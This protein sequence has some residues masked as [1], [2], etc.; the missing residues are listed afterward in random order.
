MTMRLRFSSTSLATVAI[1][2]ALAVTASASVPAAGHRAAARHRVAIRHVGRGPQLVIRRDEPVGRDRVVIPPI[3][4]PITGPNGGVYVPTA[5]KQIPLFHEPGTVVDDPASELAGGGAHLSPVGPARVTSVSANVRQNNTAGDPAGS[6]QSENAFTA[7]GGN[8][9]AGWNDGTNFGISPGNTGYAYSTNGG[10]TWTDGGV[11]PVPSSTALH[12]GDPCL[13]N[14]FA[15]HY[16]MSDLYSPDN[17]VTSAVAVTPGSF[18]GGVMV[19]NM[20]VIVASSTSDFLDKEWIAADRISGNVYCTYTRFLAAGGN[21]IEFSRST[22]LGATWSPPMVLTSPAIESVQ[23]SRVVVGPT[24]EIQVIYFV[25]DKGTGNNYMRTQRST[26]QGTSWGPEITL[27]TGPS[28][29][30]S[31]YGSGPAGFNRAGGVGF[32]SMAIDRSGGAQNGRVYATW[33]ETV[34]FYF[35]LLGSLGAVNEI[36][37]N[38]TPGTANPILIGQSIH[39]TMSSTADQ[40]WF[41]FNGVAGQTVIIYLTSGG[42]DGFLRLFACG[43]GAVANRTQLSYIGFGTGLCVYTIPSNG[44][45]FFRVLANSATVGPYTVFTGFDSPDPGDEVG[46]DT[47]D[48][49]IQS[50]PDG[51]SWDNRR[52]VNDDAPL[53]DNAFPEVAVDGAGM[54]YVDWYDH[55][56]D[57]CGIGTDV[58][59]ARS[60]NGSVTFL[61]SVKVNDGP[62][63]NWSN[64]ASNLAPNMGDYISLVADG[65]NVYASFADGRGGSP[66]CWMATI[67]DCATATM[68]SIAPYVAMPDHVDLTWMA[69]DGAGLVAT[70]ERREVGGA[71]ASLGVISPDGDG[72]LSYRDATVRAGTTYEYRLG[73]P[74]PSGTGYF[75]GVTVQVPLDLAFS[76]RALGNPLTGSM[77]FAFKLPGSGTGRIELLDVAGRAVDAKVVSGAGTVRLGGAARGGIYFVRLTAANGR[78]VTDKVVFVE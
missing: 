69:T 50:S 36:E 54:V 71:W 38:N 22:N 56:G 31:N 51:V 39:G 25:F 11:L 46:R 24:G 61:P 47:R 5:L 72:R 16:Y 4:A 21:Q 60:T 27:P 68:I 34:N 14:D 12:E 40:D 55:R 52:V 6:T 10:L 64:V 15:N 78:S 28:G 26:T 66:D 13:T 23:G 3:P 42:G 48:A 41:S 33:E 67:N 53:Y 76:V 8:A 75:G 70:V 18:S 43:G 1:L 17:N 74:T 73:V 37:S 2:A 7:D 32:P 49:I 63:I 19:W 57:P 29:I 9:V 77:D 45:Y 59:Y 35:D 62:P 20:P 58:Y 65:C 44:T 30:I